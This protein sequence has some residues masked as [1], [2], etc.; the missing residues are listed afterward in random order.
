MTTAI[1]GWQGRGDPRFR[2]GH[3][4]EGGSSATVLPVASAE[5]APGAARPPA[6]AKPAL[7]PGALA[8]EAAALERELVRRARRGDVAAFEE[9]LRPCLQPAYQL[10][11]R[12]LGNRQLAEDV[13][14]DALLK[15]FTAMG[16]FR[17]EAR[18]G[19]WIFRIVHNACTDALRYR[20]RR[21]QAPLPAAEGDG[22][23]EPVASD[24]G[25]EDV[26]IE[27]QGRAA[28]L[29]AVAALPPDHRAVVLLRDV[30][31]LSYEEVAAITG[32]NLG[33]IKSRLHR[34][35]AALR[36]ALGPDRV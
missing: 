25:P 28:L 5:P 12:L 4:L 22:G 10:A 2:A 36:A 8:A 3:R 26:V 23:P 24:P 27:R 30:Q 13:T 34:A 29:A 35:R 33:T 31:G 11:V 14:Q 18:F 19:T 6:G 1:F 21:P 15:A 20:A 32:Q 9:L 7:E 16:H 17:G